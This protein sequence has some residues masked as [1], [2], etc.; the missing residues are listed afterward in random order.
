MKMQP[1]VQNIWSILLLSLPLSDAL[2]LLLTLCHM[3]VPCS[4]SLVSTVSQLTWTKMHLPLRSILC[5]YVILV[6][7]SGCTMVHRCRAIPYCRFSCSWL[8]VVC[9]LVSGSLL[10][11]RLPQHRS[12]HVARNQLSVN[13]ALPLSHTQEMFH[14]LCKQHRFLCLLVL[15]LPPVGLT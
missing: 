12:M 14:I 11:C 1:S 9:C 4:T 6:G 3:D 8:V 13:R 5:M 15:R 10:H 2:M 7:R